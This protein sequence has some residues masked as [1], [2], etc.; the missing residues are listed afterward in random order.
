[1][2]KFITEIS[3]EDFDKLYPGWEKEDDLTYPVT[4]VVN[5]E[6]PNPGTFGKQCPYTDTMLIVK[7]V[8]HIYSTRDY[9]EVV[10]LLKPEYRYKFAKKQTKSIYLIH[11]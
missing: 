5:K 6:Y 3:K 1:M 9:F 8:K 10:S 7:S 2:N 11:K 4:V